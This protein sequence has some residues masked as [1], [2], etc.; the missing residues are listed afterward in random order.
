MT[1]FLLF[2]TQTC[3]FTIPYVIWSSIS[4]LETRYVTPTLFHFFVFLGLHPWHMEVPKL[5]VELELELPAYTT[6]TATPEL[7]FNCNLH[8][9]PRQHQILNPLREARDQTCVLKDASQ[10]S[11]SLPL[12]H[13]RNSYFFFFQSQSVFSPQF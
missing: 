11:D 8:H 12:N 4:Q 5:V 2:R 9:S 13:D 3:T 7:S 6:A 1:Q 10:M